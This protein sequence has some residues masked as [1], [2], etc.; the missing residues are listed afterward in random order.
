MAI[1]PLVLLTANRQ[2]LT[3]TFKSQCVTFCTTGALKRH[4][5]TEFGLGAADVPNA[6]DCNIEWDLARITADGTGTAYGGFMETLETGTQVA[7]STTAKQGYTAEPTVT[8]SVMVDSGSM[9]QRGWWR[10]V[11]IDPTSEPRAPAVA[12]NGFALRALSP[13]YASKLAAK[14]NFRE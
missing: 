1:Y 13:N 4:S 6:T 11:A 5:I 14:L 8:A 2:V 7:P 12:S 10:W 9:N 3:T